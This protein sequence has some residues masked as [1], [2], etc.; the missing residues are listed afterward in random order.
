[1]SSPSEPESFTD[2]VVVIP[3]IL[4]STLRQGGKEVWGLS[5]GSLTRA[6]VTFARDIKRL[7]LPDNIADEHQM[8]GCSPAA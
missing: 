2:V 3:G 8:T 1:M 6:I 7:Q 4:G 5:H